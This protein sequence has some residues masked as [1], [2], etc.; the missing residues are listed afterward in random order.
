MKQ[1][2]S[3]I[4]KIEEHVSVIAF[5]IMSI[6]VLLNVIMRYALSS[7]L[8]WAEELARY[9]MIWGVFIGISIGT[10]RG[11]HLGIE[12]FVYMLPAR[13]ADK[14]ALLAQVI[15]LVAYIGLA[16]LALTLVLMTVESGQIMPAMRKPMFIVYLAIP[17][18]FILS[19]LRQIQV[20]IKK[21]KT[22][23]MEVKDI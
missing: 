2:S 17:V 9:L 22:D 16:Y 6:V 12:A 13:I 3:I 1:G 23:S 4:D 8:S 21:T 14:I 5:T 15:V 20:I 7:P 10:R 11:A 19:T 18:G